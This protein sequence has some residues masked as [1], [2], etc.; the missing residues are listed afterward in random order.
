MVTLVQFPRSLGLPNP[1]PFCC[2]AELLMKESGIDF[3]VKFEFN[4]RKGPKGKLPAMVLDNGTV[5][6]DSEL[7]RGELEKLTGHDFDAGLNDAQRGQAHAI[8]RMVEERMYWT[9]VYSRWIDPAIAPIT[10]ANIFKD[11]PAILR[12][13]VW[14]FAT[15]GVK[16]S[17]QGHGIGKHSQAEIYEFGVRDVQSLARILGDNDWLLGDQPSSA[18]LTVWPYMCTFAMPDVPDT[19]MAR[20][21]KDNEKLMA[22]AARGWDRWFPDMKPA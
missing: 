8:C 3:D 9:L 10:K 19:P 20:A 5:V 2:K 21:V 13:V 1:S 7:M 6:G 17:L 22:Y 18:D 12:N 14:S 4:P 15:G 16:K 11:V